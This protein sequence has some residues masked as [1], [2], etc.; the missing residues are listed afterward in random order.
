[1]GQTQNMTASKTE[2]QYSPTFLQIFEQ[3]SL[4]M[5]RRKYNW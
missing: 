1:M 5:D 4:E 2:E 3:M